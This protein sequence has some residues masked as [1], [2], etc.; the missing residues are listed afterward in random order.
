[1]S[2]IGG[3]ELLVVLLLAL[4]VLGPERLPK[5]A[6]EIGRFVRKARQMSSGFQAEIRKVV[7]VDELT[8]KTAPSRGLKASGATSVS[9]LRPVTAD[10]DS[11]M[12]TEVIARNPGPASAEDEGEQPGQEPSGGSERAAG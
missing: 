9:A 11:D 6:R 3:T 1:M 2:N 7:D 8:G 12:E 5:A 4:L 10:T